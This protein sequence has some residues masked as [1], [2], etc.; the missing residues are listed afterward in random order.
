MCNTTMCND[1][2]ATS[3]AFCLRSAIDAGPARRPK[4]AADCGGTQ[5][6]DDADAEAHDGPAPPRRLGGGR[7]A[8]VWEIATPA[9]VRAVKVADRGRIGREARV[10][11]AIAGCGVAP[12]LVAAGDGLLVTER[13]AGGSRPAGEWSAAD[14]R[15]VGALLRRLHDSGAPAAAVADRG[16]ATATDRTADLRAPA[17]DADRLLAARAIAMMPGAPAPRAVLLHGDPWSG[18]VVWGTDGPLL[19]D[20]EF[21]RIGEPAEDLAY[22]AAMD[23]LLPATMDAVLI[24]YGADARTADRAAAWRPFMAL[25][26]A[27]WYSAIGDAERSARLRAHAAQSIDGVPG[28]RPGAG[29]A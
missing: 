20:W 29:Y 21:A 1:Y 6:P 19:V 3:L 24:G 2:V 23:T 13:I 25:W 8:S 11:D 9:G 15:A 7:G 28:S 18:N 17:D 27:T 4:D 12:H 16:A 5:M 10:H 22:L 26:C 14:A